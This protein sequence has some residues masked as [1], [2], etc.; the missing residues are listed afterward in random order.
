M[1][2]L[3]QYSASIVVAALTIVCLIVGILALTVLRPAQEIRATT[4]ATTP[5]ITTRDGVFTLISSE[6]TVTATSSTGGPVAIALGSTTDVAG[7]VATSAYT[8][9]VG[10]GADR[11]SL[12]VED[13][14]AATPAEESTT[15]TQ[16]TQTESTDS[17]ATDNAATTEAATTEETTPEASTASAIASDMWIQEV[18]ATGTATMTVSDIGAGKSLLIAT[19][20]TSADFQVEIV[21]RTPRTNVLAIA[22][23]TL[24]SVFALIA[25]ILALLTWRRAGASSAWSSKAL[26]DHD[27]DTVQDEGES[28]ES[29]QNEAFQVQDAQDEIALDGAVKDEAFLDGAAFA[30]NTLD[31]ASQDHADLQA[32]PPHEYDSDAHIDD[33]SQTVDDGTLAHWDD[34]AVFVPGAMDPQLDGTVE[35]E[36][37]FND[38][39]SEASALHE[40]EANGD[41]Y[42]ADGYQNSEAYAGQNSQEAI[43]Q[44]SIG[45]HGLGHVTDEDPPEKVPTDT[46][47]IDLSAVR[48]GAVLPSR[49]ALRE[50][51]EQGKDR[52]IIDG[53]EF[54]TGLIPI[55]GDSGD[56]ESATDTDKPSG[57]WSSMMA[58]WKDRRN[59]GGQ[60]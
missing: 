49:R 1:E 7:W 48:P 58:A 25:V 26:A 14:A 55:V 12:K 51:R 54:D 36:I 31:E 38:T 35:D 47:I 32:L 16:E 24:A 2:R 19:D 28:A 50:A 43:E 27:A 22:A 10:I 6:A 4:A 17:A 39:E 18:A 33:N 40:D 59:K 44:P 56:T 20:G 13:H 29:A 11:T 52:I 15:T 53:K 21:W 34:T 57:T 23:F 5:Y 37:P 3:R 30:D 8:E 60:P 45:R 41:D 9:V 46:G 42:R